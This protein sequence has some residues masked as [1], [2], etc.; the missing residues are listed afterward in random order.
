MSGERRDSDWVQ[1]GL[2]RSAKARN[3]RLGKMRRELSSHLPADDTQ[4]LINAFAQLLS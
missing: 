3:L 1:K 4:L 2:P